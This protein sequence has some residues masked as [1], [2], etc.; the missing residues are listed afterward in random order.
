[1]QF[2]RFDCVCGPRRR[3]LYFRHTQLHQLENIVGKVLL[4]FLLPRRG[5]GYPVR[6]AYIIISA[7]KVIQTIDRT[8]M[9]MCVY[10]TIQTTI[11]RSR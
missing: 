9:F 4:D 3:R 6:I 7:W 1:M 8:Y 2:Y 10:G 5:R 11:G